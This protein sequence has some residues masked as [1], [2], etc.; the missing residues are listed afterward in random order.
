MDPQPFLAALPATG[1]HPDHAQE[2]MLFGRFVGEWRVRI[3]MIQDGEIRYDEEGFWSFAWVLDGRAIQDVLIAPNY[4]TK[5]D[6][7]GERSIGTTVR[8]FNPTTEEWD[9]V[10]FGATTGV[11]ARLTGRAVGDEIWIEA[12]DNGLHVRWV[13]TDITDDAFHWRGMASEDPSGT[14]TL[15]QEMFAKRRGS[16]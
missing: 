14:W 7:V 10:W 11:L 13:F 16:G 2:L 3:H 4:A 15:M 6:G 12:E 1:P 5:S 9:V 8:Y